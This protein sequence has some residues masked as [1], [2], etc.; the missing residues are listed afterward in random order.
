MRNLGRAATTLRSDGSMRKKYIWRQATDSTRTIDQALQACSSRFLQLV[1]KHHI[2]TDGEC[3]IGKR[4]VV[5][6]KLDERDVIESHHDSRIAHGGIPRFVESRN[7]RHWCRGW[8]FAQQFRREK[9]RQVFP[10]FRLVLTRAENRQHFREAGVIKRKWNS[11][12]ET[13]EHLN[14]RPKKKSDGKP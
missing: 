8:R 7:L 12:F 5:F 13:H 6:E 1:K 9:D 3:C 2:G 11:N 4:G 10:V 14:Q